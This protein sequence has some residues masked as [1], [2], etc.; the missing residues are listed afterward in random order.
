MPPSTVCCPC[1]LSVLH[2]MA[3]PGMWYPWCSGCLEWCHHGGHEANS[4]GS[5]EVHAGAVRCS[6]HMG[7][8]SAVGRGPAGPQGH[9][10]L[11]N[12]AMLVDQCTMTLSKKMCTRDGRHIFIKF[13]GQRRRGTR[14]GNVV[15]HL[16]WIFTRRGWKCSRVPIPRMA[17][18]RSRWLGRWQDASQILFVYNGPFGVLFL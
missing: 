10:G 13:L 7:S 5:Y 1:M 2:S 11:W 12:W 18:P 17:F 3:C 4:D 9:V 15:R 16:G 8:S 6:E 14:N